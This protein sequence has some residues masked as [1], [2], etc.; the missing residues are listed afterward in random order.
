MRQAVIYAR[1]S[2]GSSQT[3]QSIEGQLTECYKFAR[4]N[5]LQIIRTYEDEHLTGRNDQRPAFQQ[6]LKDSAT[7]K[8]DIVLVYAIDRF[9]RNSIEIAINKYHLQKNGKTVISATQRT[10]RNLDGSKNLDGILL[11]NFYIG[12]AE[13]YSEELSQKVMRGLRESY[14]K[15]NFTGGRPLLGYKVVDDPRSASDRKPRKIVVIDEDTAP[16]VRYIFEEYAKGTPKKTIIAELTRRGYKNKKNKPLSLTS[17]QANLTCRKY[18]GE[19]EHEGVVYTNI[20]PPLIDKATFETVQKQLAKRKHAPAALKAREDYILQGK[21]FCGHCGTRMVGVCGTSRDG[22]LHHYYACGKRYKY[23]TC[24]KRSEKKD[25]IEQLVVE[26]TLEYVLEPK[27]IDFIADRVMALYRDEF[28]EDNVKAIDRRVAALEDEI[29]KAVNAF[30]DADSKMVRAKLNQRVEDLEAQKNELLNDRDGLV[31]ASKIP[32]SKAQFI[33]WLKTF[34]RGNPAD[35]DFQ[36]RVVDT[37]INSFYLY[38][39]KFIIYFNID[40]AEVVGYPEASEDVE[41]AENFEKNE[42]TPATTG[43]D[44]VR[45]S[46][47]TLHHTTSNTNPIRL[48]F[49][50]GTARVLLER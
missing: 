41:L 4:A 9:G 13:Y 35:K 30:I 46:N 32:V 39:D 29:E 7:A 34:E 22:T 47:A 43:G 24:D 17:F 21:A 3:Y 28:N 36:K 42:N 50:D 27:R 20:Y 19:V 33:S 45:I 16:L 12:M 8:W 2:P 40:G 14:A 18:I 15:G 10:A 38:D 31:A 25:F 48:V 6:L 49:I 37:L 5:D 11:E 1:Y 44:S 23:H 26:L